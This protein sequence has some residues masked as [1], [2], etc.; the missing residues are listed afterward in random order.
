MV[1]PGNYLAARSKCRPLFWD[2]SC[3]WESGKSAVKMKKGCHDLHHC[4]ACTSACLS[5]EEE[6]NLLA[7]KVCSKTKKKGKKKN[8]KTC[9]LICLLLW[10]RLLSHVQGGYCMSRACRWLFCENCSIAN[11]FLQM[12]NLL[13]A[14]RV[15]IR[16]V[17]CFISV[18]WYI[19]L[20]LLLNYFHFL[21][22]FISKLEVFIMHGQN[23]NLFF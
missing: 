20:F 9:F 17:W 12:V 16:F 7:R 23:N 6:Q 2:P 5:Q 18:I 11:R 21:F 19:W 4:W 13:K 14:R 1:V 22:I 3:N 15:S 10:F 8:K